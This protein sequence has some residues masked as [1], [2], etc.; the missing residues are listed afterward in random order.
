MGDRPFYYQTTDPSQN[1]RVRIRIATVKPGGGPGERA[2][3]VVGWQEKRQ[4]PRQ[5]AAWALQHQTGQH[6]ASGSLDDMIAS[7]E[8]TGAWVFSVTDAECP[9]TTVSATAATPASPPPSSWLP[10]SASGGT[11]SAADQENQGDQ[12][13]VSMSNKT[14]QS[15]FELQAS[16]MSAANSQVMYI[17]A[18]TCRD[19]RRLRESVKA[20]D[21][22]AGHRELKASG[23]QEHMLCAVTAHRNGV[24][25]AVP[26]FSVEES[27]NKFEHGIF[28]NDTELKDAATKGP[29]LTTYFLD[30]SIGFLA[31]TLENIAAA[32][33]LNKIEQIVAVER[34]KDE[35]MRLRLRSRRNEFAKV[36]KHADRQLHL[37]LE[38]SSISGL[39]VP[40][41]FCEYQILMPHGWAPLDPKM[42][43]G[44]A[45]M[46]RKAEHEEQWSIGGISQI[47]RVQSFSAAPR[48]TRAAHVACLV[49]FLGLLV[50]VGDDPES[51]LL[52][53][54]AAALLLSM[55]WKDSGV[56]VGGNAHVNLSI[57]MDMACL[58]EG[59]NAK[60]VV[61]FELSSIDFFNRCK[62]EGY[63]SVTLPACACNKLIEVRMVRPA[64]RTQY[65][66]LQE[67]FVGGVN[68]ARD[69]EDIRAERVSRQSSKL[70]GF[71]NRSSQSS[72]STGGVLKGR[73]VAWERRQELSGQQSLGRTTTRLRPNLSHILERYSRKAPQQDDFQKLEGRM[74]AQDVTDFVARM[75]ESRLNFKGA[76]GQ[77][78][79]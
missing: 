76:Y 71:R 56:A 31:Y 39:V 6:V 61:H 65:E 72:V 9:P 42:S 33:D 11:L 47:A 16:D 74:T 19:P 64:P 52:V 57:P 5:C 51:A 22:T 79:R 60:P 44:S 25:E 49:V 23:Y 37:R 53:C 40:N 66:A 35:S 20:T 54:I 55:S 77:Q 17:M 34:S 7:L 69:L 18:A 10:F 30:T 75:K 1:L 62:V 59:V 27:G 21:K 50:T 43:H 70:A 8:R 15:P 4:S 2:E 68:R 3:A 63:G 41:I 46:W 24:F 58:D 28:V 67:C 38:L 12:V 73:I 48:T 45:D 29:C 13:L 78:S 32:S 36:H 26:G 14:V